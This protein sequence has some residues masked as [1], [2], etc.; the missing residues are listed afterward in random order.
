MKNFDDDN[1]VYMYNVYVMFPAPVSTKLQAAAS[2]NHVQCLVLQTQMTNMM[3]L[4]LNKFEKRTSQVQFCLLPHL[5]SLSV[6]PRSSSMLRKYQN[7][8]RLGLRLSTT[9][10]EAQATLYSAASD[11]PAG[12]GMQ[13][14]SHF[15][16]SVKCTKRCVTSHKFDNLYFTTSGST[17]K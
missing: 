6:L 10:L 14:E 16:A 12:N 1:D 8:W 15:Q 13:K 11:L 5:A 4:S 7:L 3:H 9:G 2:S 17:I